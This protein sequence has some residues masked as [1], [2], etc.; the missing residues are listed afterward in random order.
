MEATGFEGIPPTSEVPDRSRAPRKRFRPP[1]R[2]LWLA[3]YRSVYELGF[4]LLAAPLLL[5]A[6]AGD[7][8]PVLVLPGFLASDLST[9]PLRRYLARLGYDAYAW[10]LGRNFGGVMRMRH[11]LRRR[12]ASIHAAT[13]RKVSIVGWSLGGIYARMLALDEADAVRS[14]I[15]LGTPFS[16]DPDA[17]NVSAVYEAVSGERR[18]DEERRARTVFA[19]AFDRIGGDLA[20]PSTSIYSKLDGVVDWRASLLRENGRTENIEV[21]GASH[22]GLGVNAAVLWATADRLAQPEGTFAPFGRGGPFALAYAR[23]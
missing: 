6:P 9:E 23:P 8:H 22:V 13:G 19:H 18:S 1:S 20:V 5:G 12:L 2:L 15:T 7:G 21:F 4:S 14:V 11:T 17:S 16:R 10:D 3:E